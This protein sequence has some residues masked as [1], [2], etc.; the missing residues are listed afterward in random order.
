MGEISLEKQHTETMAF[1]RFDFYSNFVVGAWT[2][3]HA[4][5]EQVVLIRDLFDSFFRGEPYGYIGNRVNAHSV[6]VTKV[7]NV[8]HSAVNLKEIAFVIY[9]EIGQQV[10]MIEK[11]VYRSHDLQVFEDLKEAMLWMHNAMKAYELSKPGKNA[12]TA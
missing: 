11:A 4:T 10:V 5:A 6:D 2:D 1:G 3:D 12:R 9:S 7:R 8:L